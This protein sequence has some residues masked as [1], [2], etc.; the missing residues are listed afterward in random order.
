MMVYRYS[1]LQ[2]IAIVREDGTAVSPIMSPKRQLYHLLLHAVSCK[3]DVL[4]GH[5]IG[6]YLCDP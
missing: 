1:P 4:C 6:S 3:A 2:H 5:K